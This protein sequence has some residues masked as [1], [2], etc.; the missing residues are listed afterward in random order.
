MNRKELP[1]LSATFVI[2]IAALRASAALAVEI[3]T[4]FPLTIDA[5]SAYVIY[6]HGAI[7]EGIDPRPRHSRWGTYNFPSI[8]KSILPKS[9]C[10]LSG[11]TEN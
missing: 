3:H 11:T 4:E 6:P 2:R 5:E 7:V 9:E 10:L 1:G 8:K